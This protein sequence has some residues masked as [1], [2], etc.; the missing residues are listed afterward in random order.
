MLKV[1]DVATLFMATDND[2]LQARQA[3]EADEQYI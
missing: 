3:V 2:F 1:H